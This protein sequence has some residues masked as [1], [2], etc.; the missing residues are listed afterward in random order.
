M[1]QTV[2][3][4]VIPANPS[5]EVQ[6]NAL[7]ERYRSASG[8]GMQVV[9]MLGAQAEG[10]LD[11]LPAPARKGLDAATL[12]ALELSFSAAEASRARLPDTGH[13]LTR[14]VTAATGAA[15]GFGG[16][17]TSLAEV[18][19][20]TTVM[21]RAIQAIAAEY[22]F[23][24]ADPDTRADC[25]RV[26]A[27]AGPMEEDDGTDLSFLTLRASVTGATLQGLINT[28]AP[29]LAATLGRKLAA[30]MVPVLGAVSG[31]AINYAFTSYYQD[32]AHV[33][34][35]LRK[36]AEETGHDRSALIAEFVEIVR[37]RK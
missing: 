18:P 35:G 22:G 24:P 33:Q 1:T 10:L 12:Q 6:L 14:A 15:G 26:F 21:L 20:T 7:A 8:I 27:A 31:A 19:V 23:D 4:P 32:I 29:R 28:I 5:K 2:L 11:K 3:P 36:L 34:F 9:N 25:L 30:Q 16:V 17:T 13:W 37:S